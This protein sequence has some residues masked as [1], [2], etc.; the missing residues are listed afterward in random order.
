MIVYY[1]PI[2]PVITTSQAVAGAGVSLWMVVQVIG[3]EASHFIFGHFLYL[4]DLPV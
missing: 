2:Q 4:F 3:S 1:K